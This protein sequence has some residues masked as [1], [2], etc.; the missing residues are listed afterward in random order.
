MC[1]HQYIYLPCGQCVEHLAATFAFHHARKQFN[2]HRHIAQKLA[3]GAEVLLGQ[4]LG[5]R[6]DARL[7][8]IVNSQQHGHQGHERFARSHVALQQAVHLYTASHIGT[9][10]VHHTLLRAC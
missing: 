1:A 10:L 3:N 2:T 5:G 9:Y 4:Y 8:A 7:K 6:H